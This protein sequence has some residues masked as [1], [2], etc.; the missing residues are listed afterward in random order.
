MSGEEL[1]QQLQVSR[2]AVWKHIE[3][4]RKEGYVIEAQ[5]KLGYKILKIPTTLS[6]NPILSKL[7]T[8]WLGQALH[9]F[10]EVDSTQGIAQKLAREGCPSGTVVIADRQLAG[11]GR[12]GRVWYSPPEKGIW[13]SVILRP[14]IPVTSAP[15]LTLLASVAILKGMTKVTGLDIG[16]KWPNDLLIQNRKLAGILT[17]L[18][19]EPDHINHVIVGV[20]I[21]VNHS[22]EDFPDELKE[23]ATSLLIEGKQEVDRNELIVTILK[24]WEDLFELYLAHGFGPIKTLWEAYTVSLGKE[25]IARTM[26]GEYRGKA[27]GINDEGVLLLEDESKTIHKIYSADIETV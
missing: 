8:K 24:E 16:I 5:K 26:R 12:M 4:L 7:Q 10:Q 3:E 21:N 22:L 13:M 9:T 23:I 6:N 1:S 11:K 27:L 17:E 25:V 20:G 19:A 15:Q 14:E 18:S 2:T